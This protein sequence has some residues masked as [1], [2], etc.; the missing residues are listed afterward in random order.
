MLGE[1]SYPPLPTVQKPYP[2]HP[3]L[4]SP[5]ASSQKAKLVSW[6]GS[7]PSH[8]YTF[9]VLPGLGKVTPGSMATSHTSW[10]AC[11]NSLSTT[12]SDLEWRLHGL[13]NLTLAHHCQRLKRTRT[14]T[15]ETRLLHILA[16]D[17]L[18]FFTVLNCLTT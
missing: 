7:S 15:L 14:G 9:P 17:T 1:Q 12:G 5:P 18:N 2:L 6:E 13:E 3:C 4:H 11:L 16:V 10:Q 8:P